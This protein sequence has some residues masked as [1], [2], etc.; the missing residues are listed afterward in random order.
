MK[1]LLELI[2]RS[3]VTQPEAVRVQEDRRDRQCRLRLQVA[4][5]DM[6][7]VIGRGG[8]IARAIRL[9]MRAAAVHEGVSLRV[10]IGDAPGEEEQAEGDVGTE[11]VQAAVAAGRADATEPVSTG[12]TPVAS[13]AGTLRP[14]WARRRRPRRRA[15][16]GRF[17]R[18]RSAP[19]GS[20]TVPDSSPSIDNGEGSEQGGGSGGGRQ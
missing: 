3:L 11:Q 2:A 18:P 7:K 13:S 8:Q 15:R 1:E 4:P 14:A 9:V 19:G 16:R 17:A 12:A 6:G 5:E 10:D 20:A